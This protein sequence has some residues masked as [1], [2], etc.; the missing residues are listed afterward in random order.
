MTTTLRDAVSEDDP[1]LLRVFACTREAE[2]AHVPWTDEQRDAFL[3]MQFNA[4]HSYYHEHYPEADYKVILHDGEPVG[5]IYINREPGQSKILDITV[6]PE[7]RQRGIG[8]GLI[9]EVLSEASESG[10]NVHVYVETFNPSLELFKKLGFTI[11][12]EE[13]I[14]YLLE[15]TVASGATPPQ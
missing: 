9:R 8:S 4:Q 11:L 14:N 15:W 13:G 12:K 5:R 10:R 3:R 6:L 7:F 1:F 2:F